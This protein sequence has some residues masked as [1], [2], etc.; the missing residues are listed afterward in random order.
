MR[1]H[2][3]CLPSALAGSW[4]GNGAARTQPQVL[5]YRL[6]PS[7][8]AA[9]QQVH[10]NGHLSWLPFKWQGHREEKKTKHNE[11]PKRPF[12]CGR[13]ILV[14]KNTERSS[15]SADFTEHSQSVLNM[16]GSSGF[17]LVE[18][19]GPNPCTLRSMYQHHQRKVN[20]FTYHAKKNPFYLRSKEPSRNRHAQLHMCGC[21]SWLSLTETDCSGDPTELSATKLSDPEWD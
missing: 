2:I 11:E 1:D 21:G 7:Q 5:Q 6:Q 16:T 10:H 20:S 14:R 12:L 3:C 8:A 15:P 9:L 17:T 18:S 19:P 4:I 13:R